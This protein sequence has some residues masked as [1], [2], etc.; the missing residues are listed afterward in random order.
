[1]V[2]E[3]AISSRSSHRTRPQQDWSVARTREKGYIPESPVKKAVFGPQDPREDFSGFDS[4]E[5]EDSEMSSMADGE[6]W[7]GDDDRASDS[8]APSIMPEPEYQRHHQLMQQP[9]RSAVPL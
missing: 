8:I 1:V 2:Q 4:E 9:P 5:E 7:I 3:S 6:E